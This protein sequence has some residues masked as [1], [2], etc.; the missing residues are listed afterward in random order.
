MRLMEE[1]IPP[2]GGE[3]VGS[4]A[5]QGFARPEKDGSGDVHNVDGA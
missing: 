2:P 1:E 3:G 5:R 4:A